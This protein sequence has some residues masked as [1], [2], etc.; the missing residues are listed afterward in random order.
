MDSIMFN[1]TVRTEDFSYVHTYHRP[2]NSEGD[3]E[4]FKDYVQ[5]LG[6]ML[7]CNYVSTIRKGD[8]YDEW[9]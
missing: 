9:I 2:F 8:H 7:E 3:W 6:Y 4:L 1:V 5:A